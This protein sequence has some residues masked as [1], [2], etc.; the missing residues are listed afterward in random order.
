MNAY[1]SI[2]RAI[3]LALKKNYQRIFLDE[4]EL[5]R[6]ILAEQIKINTRL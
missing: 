6:E 1:N 3:E 5:M 2:R 4:G